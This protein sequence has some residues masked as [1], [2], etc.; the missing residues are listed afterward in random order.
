[1]QTA[2]GHLMMVPDK[3]G[4]AKAL[5][6]EPPTVHVLR[7]LRR[8][9][10]DISY[11]MCMPH[12]LDQVLYLFRKGW[13]V[14]VTAYVGRWGE[15]SEQNYAK[16]KK[17]HREMANYLGFDPSK[18]I[19]GPAAD[20]LFME[21]L[22]SHDFKTEDCQGGMGA[23]MRR[24]QTTVL[25]SGNKYMCSSAECAG[26]L[27]YYT[28]PVNGY[29]TKKMQDERA[30]CPRGGRN[31]VNDRIVTTSRR[32]HA[33]H[34]R[35]RHNGIAS[36]I[37]AFIYD[38][39]AQ[40]PMVG[41]MFTVWSEA[42]YKYPDMNHFTM[43]RSEAAKARMLPVYHEKIEKIKAYMVTEARKTVHQQA[44]ETT[45]RRE[46]RQRDE[47]EIARLE[48]QINDLASQDITKVSV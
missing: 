19:H 1:M 22:R 38:T 47:A 45:S 3:D 21:M 48:K 15:H 31:D 9:C 29:G 26:F 8:V 44:P 32:L 6:G 37:N 24:H 28:E 10:I 20:G 27:P 42:V 17:I 7:T 14:W 35:T 16:I 13:V 34:H 4:I 11:G 5:L 33:L 23:L 30:W 39:D 2:D 40:V 43:K 36:A 46:A 12:A 41:K 18:P 25:I